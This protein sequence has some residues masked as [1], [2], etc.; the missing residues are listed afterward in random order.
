MTNLTSA[1]Q[2][3][4]DLDVHLKLYSAADILLCYISLLSSRALAQPLGHWHWHWHRQCHWYWNWQP[5]SVW[6][7]S[8]TASCVSHCPP[9]KAIKCTWR[10]TSAEGL[11]HQD[12]HY[13]GLQYN[14]SMQRPTIQRHTIPRATIKRPKIPRRTIQRPT[15]QRPTVPRPTIQS[16]I[17]WCSNISHPLI[18]TEHQTLYDTAHP[19][20]SS[21]LFCWSNRTSWNRHQSRSLIFKNHPMLIIPECKSGWKWGQ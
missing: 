18:Y 7:K 10:W 4:Y 12:L 11:Q 6:F 3:P 5:P 16:H 13:N 20:L 15:I 8:R 2:H 14:C 19:K 17:M 1:L 9:C 21:Y